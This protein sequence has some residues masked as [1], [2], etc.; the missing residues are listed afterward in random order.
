MTPWLD[1]TLV[2]NSSDLASE[3]VYVLSA[4]LVT[5]ESMS[6]NILYFLPNSLVPTMLSQARALFTK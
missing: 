4:N 3:V 2:S 6:K 5:N 1:A